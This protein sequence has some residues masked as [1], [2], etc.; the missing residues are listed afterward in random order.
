LKKFGL[1]ILPAL[2]LAAGLAMP[3]APAAADVIYDVSFDIAGSPVTGTFV[4]D[5]ASGPPTP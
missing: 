1:S 3:V 4:T 2:L 5:I